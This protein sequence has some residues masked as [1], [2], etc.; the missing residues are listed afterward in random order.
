MIVSDWS[1]ALPELSQTYEDRIFELRLLYDQY[2]TENR[3]D[4]DHN[5]L[6]YLMRRAERPIYNRLKAEYIKIWGEKATFSYFF[7]Y[8][9]TNTIWHRVTDRLRPIREGKPPCLCKSANSSS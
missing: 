7:P 9:T 4:R 3:S 5:L 2:Q 8:H 6:S 1:E